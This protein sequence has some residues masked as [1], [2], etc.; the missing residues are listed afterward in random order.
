VFVIFI[1]F[2][3]HPQFIGYKKSCFLLQESAAC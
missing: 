1:G 3:N 2:S